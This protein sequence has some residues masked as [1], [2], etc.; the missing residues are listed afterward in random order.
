[1]KDWLLRDWCYGDAQRAYQ[2]A[3]VN[4]ARA[5]SRPSEE[6]TSELSGALA[7]LDGPE[8]FLLGTLADGSPVRVASR[9]IGRH[10]LVWGSSGAGKSYGLHILTEGWTA[11]GKRLELID[12]KGETYLLKALAAAAAYES[13]PE[14]KREKF[15]A[16]FR[17]F[18]VTPERVTPSDL[19]SVPAGMSPALLATLRAAAVAEMSS[20]AFSDLMAYGIVLIYSVAINLGWGITMKIARAFFLDAAFRERIAKKVTE[21]RLRDSILHLDTTLPEQTRK[22]IVRQFDLLLASLPARI[23]FGLSPAMIRELLPPRS[24]PAPTIALGNFGPTPQRPPALAKAMATN[25]LIDVLTE[26]NVRS[27]AVSELLLLEEVGVLVK[28]PAVADYLLEASRT[29][30]WKG[31]SIVCVAQDPAN[32]IPKETVTALVLNSKWLLAFECGKEEA[33]WLLPHMPQKGKREAEERRMFLAEMAKLPTQEAVFVRK[34][35]PGLR[36]RLRDVEDPTRRY[37]RERLMRV[38]E[39]QIAA[40]SMIETR[41]AEAKIARFEAVLF[42]ER[43]IPVRKDERSPHQDPKTPGSIEGFFALLEDARKPKG[44]DP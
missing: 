3:R 24:G 4:E 8:H 22:A 34:G 33:L 37:P 32:A 27:A 21:E 28:Q 36:L 35:L 6:L 16:R 26:A 9:E 38:F 5:A 19:W 2:R 43:E 12:P 39:E 10:A 11:S 18:D 1:M 31:L 25:R 14:D 23:G 44:T 30:R 29:L 40:R 42:G 7:A 15:A 20:H 17:V 41:A 13:L